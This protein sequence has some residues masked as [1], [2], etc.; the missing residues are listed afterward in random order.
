MRRILKSFGKKRREIPRLMGIEGGVNAGILRITGLTS[1]I[2]CKAIIVDVFLPFS[3]F[4]RDGCLKERRFEKFWLYAEQHRTRRGL[5]KQLLQR[6]GA[7]GVRGLKV[8]GGHQVGNSVNERPG[9]KLSV[10]IA[11]A[12]ESIKRGQGKYQFCAFGFFGNIF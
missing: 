8:G 12:F 10:D 2:S 11:A 5:F 1:E 9:R 6:F 3:R 4:G 7:R